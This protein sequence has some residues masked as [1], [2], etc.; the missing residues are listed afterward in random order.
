MYATK[1]RAPSRSPG[2]AALRGEAGVIT[3]LAMRGMA[4]RMVTNP[5]TL[6]HAMNGKMP[7]VPMPSLAAG[8][9][10]PHSTGVMNRSSPGSM[11]GRTRFIRRSLA[12][13][14][15]SAPGDGDHGAQLSGVRDGQRIGLVRGEI[16]RRAGLQASPLLE[17][18]ETS[19]PDREQTNGF[20][21]THPL[22]RIVVVLEGPDAQHRVERRHR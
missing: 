10:A 16:C 8:N 21:T 1:I 3:P 7:T 11:R 17:M 19:G 22:G 15:L 20:V 9:V 5:T 4:R 18:C 14:H 6:V 2:P 12:R 13:V